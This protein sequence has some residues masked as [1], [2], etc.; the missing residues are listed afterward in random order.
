MPDQKERLPVIIIA[1]NIRSLYNVG[2]LFRAA[3]GVYLEGLYL[4]GITAYP[5]TEN[6]DRPAWMAERADRH[7]RKTGLT[8]VQSIPFR[9]FKTTAEAITHARQEKRQ[10]IGLEHTATSTDY[11]QFPYRFPLAIVIGHET[12]GV[13]QELLPHLDGTVH[14]PMRGQG[15]SLNVATATSAFL[16]YLAD[17][18]FPIQ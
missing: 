5:F 7:I 17:R 10:V 3:D 2:S 13:D 4:C 8:G 11:R 1:D 14:L 6:D 16:Y 9:Y 15:V 12:D 18:Y